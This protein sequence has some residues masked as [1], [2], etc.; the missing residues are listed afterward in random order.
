MATALVTGATAGIGAEFAR[1]LA[2]R[3]DDLV[4]VARDVGR[5][6]A[7][8]DELAARHRVKVDVLVADL[9]DRAALRTSRSAS[10]TS[11]VRSTCS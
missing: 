2:A 9:T 4:L 7:Y 6:R 1:Q 3:G 11:R 5:L 10:P 8:A